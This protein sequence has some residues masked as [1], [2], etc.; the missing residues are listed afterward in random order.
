MRV[1]TV[2]SIALLVAFVQVL[3]AAPTSPFP[4]FPYCECDPIGAYKLEQNIIFKGNGTYCFKVKVD[5]PAGCTS[6][7]CT[8]A[9]LKKVEFSVNQKCDVP[10]LLLTATLNGVPTTVNPNIELA[11]QGPTGATIVKITQLGLNLSNANGA[12]ICLTL[13]TNRAGKGCTTLED[14]CVPPAGAPPGVCT[15]ALFSSD[16]DCC[17]PSV[18]NP[19]PPP[20]PP[21]P[22]ATC[23]NISLTVTSSP[24]PYNFPP[25]V[26]DT[27]A[28]AVI[29]NLTSAAE[30]AGAT[31]SVP[32]NLSTCSGN[33]VSICG[34][35]A[36]EADSML[37]QD[38]ANDLAADFLSI[39]TGRFGTCPPYLE[40][41]N[42]AVSIDGTADT[43]P[44][45]NAIQ[46]IS[47]SRENVSFPKC[48]CD[49][50]LGATP[51]AALPFYSVQ[52]GRLKT[53]TQYCFKF[54]TIPTITGPC[55][56]ATIF[57]KVEFWGNENLRRNIRGFAIK[58]TGATNYTIISAS[59]GAR[60][61]ET[62]KA[63][64]L[65]WNIGQ[66]AGSEICMDIDTTISL[67]DFC[68]GPFSGGCYL[69][70]FDPTRKCCPMF[71]VLDGP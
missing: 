57:S 40:G 67:K 15:A 26:C 39:V 30:A 18:V 60:G 13:G 33:L 49:T 25:E 50:R 23:I 47:C 35:F 64:P 14:L 24:F 36:S 41:H 10:G 8:Q 5:V 29:A 62:V 11:A 20:P 12:E 43:R 9:D 34:A 69:N 7:C 37:L 28:A 45:L 17:P 59:W 22:C 48:I 46:S 16:T 1:G 65:N 38:A 19:P 54:T 42:L 44:C 68:L 31:I 66:A 51:Y 63:T 53:T 70:I 4:N 55:S 6:P 52:P 61:D 56:N 21:A 27:Y 58:P 2:L 32:F 3:K 71:V